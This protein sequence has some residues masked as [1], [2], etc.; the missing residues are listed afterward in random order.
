MKL[1]SVDP[2]GKTRH[3]CLTAGCTRS[4][5]GKDI[6]AGIVFD[7]KNHIFKVGRDTK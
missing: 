3:D 1:R 6:P 5:D 7:K 4:L 2:D